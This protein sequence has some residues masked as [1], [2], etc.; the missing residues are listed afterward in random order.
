M[1]LN[2]TITLYPSAYTDEFDNIIR[3]NPIIT[4]ELD[5]SFIIRRKTG[6]IY[7]QIV[8]IP[9]VIVLTTPTDNFNI[10]LLTLSDFEDILIKKLG[11]Y[12][13]KFLQNLFPKTIESDPNGPGSILSSL[14]SYVG[15]KSTSNCSCKQRAIE[16][17]EKG[18][19]WCE[20]NIG[21][22]L[23]WLK[24]ESENRKIPFIESIAKLI[25][26]RAIN[27][28]RKLKNEK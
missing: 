17:N 8:G 7:A 27:I 24:E 19:D 4:E 1:K 18:N 23:E 6:M 21:T 16:M 20:E 28:S 15:I 10:D 11:D 25:V 3:P 26:F 12:P 14:L 9:G 5:V 2:K 22:I 13:E